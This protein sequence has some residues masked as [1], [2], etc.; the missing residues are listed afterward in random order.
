MPACAGKT[1]FDGLTMSGNGGRERERDSVYHERPLF[2]LILS[3]SKGVSESHPARMVRQARHE[4][5]VGW[6]K[7]L[8]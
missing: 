5:E 8:R 3:L 7:F 6:G 1:W 4:R 2:P